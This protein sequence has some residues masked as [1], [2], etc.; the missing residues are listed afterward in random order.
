LKVILSV[1]PIKYPLTGIGRYTFELA[2][3]LANFQDVDDLRFFRGTQLCDF[4]PVPTAKSTP[5]HGLRGRILKSRLA[6]ELYRSIAP[7]LKAQALR[8][9]E[10]YVYHGPNFYLPPFE[11]VSVVTMH[12]LSPY[13]WAECHPPERVRYMR[14]EIELSLRRATKLITDSEFTR[15]ELAGHFAW[16]LD[17]IHAVPLASVSEFYPREVSELHGLQERYGLTAGGYSLF[18][19]TIEPRKNIVALLDAYSRLPEA[20]RRRWPLIL[21]G[22]KGWNSEAIHTRITEAERAG[23]ARYLGFVASEDLPL[24]YS[25]AR[26]FV[27]PSLYE[28]FGLPVLE[29]MAS[30]IPVVCSNA[31]SLPE[32][33]SD[34]AA[35]CDPSDIEALT[36]LMVAGLHDEQWRASART[37]G[38]ARAAEFSWQRCARET[39]KVYQSLQ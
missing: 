14:S 23:W 38:L 32:V 11:G 5:L 1:D 13:R 16:P 22:Y 9:F 29:A 27:F 10:D 12:D 35:L 25:G 2:T 33:A 3:A 18:V 8:G 7:R 30:G 15:K 17:N 20:T 24:L 31:S 28:G 6:V 26:L 4:I 36:G 39:A 34:A 19:G 21:A 37:K